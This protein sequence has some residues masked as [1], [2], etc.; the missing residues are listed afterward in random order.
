MSGT[1]NA[2]A[3]EALTPRK[4][5][6]TFGIPLIARS[7]APDWRRVGD[8]LELTLRSVL[9]QS[10][11]DFTLLLAGHDAPESWTDLTRGDPR[12][13]FLRAD[14]NP[15]R[16]TTRNDDGGCKKWMIKEHVREAGGGL[17]MY[18]DADDLIDR[19]LVETAR[20]RMRPDDV[21]AVVNGGIMLDFKSLRAVRLP[22]PRVYDGHFLELCGSS[23]IG[24]VEPASPDPVRRD[25]HEALG[26]HHAWPEAAAA[27][28]V[29]L[30]RLP[31]QGAYLVN[32]A[33]NHSELH[34]PFAEWRRELNDAVAREGTPLDRQTAACFG[35]DLDLLAAKSGAPGPE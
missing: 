6:F 31:V 9:A 2:S 27:S 32:T 30:A 22:H 21:G 14:W 24:R 17:L 18:L 8:L 20:A 28:G 5:R 1:G 13:R 34:G 3:A 33:Q 25:P 26:S 35:I 19:H 29:A 10:D 7:C 16:P 4:E 15:E 11:G 23:T 12:F